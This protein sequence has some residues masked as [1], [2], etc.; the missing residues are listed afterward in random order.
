MQ[1]GIYAI[2]DQAL[3]S[4]QYHRRCCGRS[5]ANCTSGT[6]LEDDRPKGDIRKKD[7]DLIAARSFGF[8]VTLSSCPLPLDESLVSSPVHALDFDIR[9]WI[10]TPAPRRL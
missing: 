7:G 2:S 9:G 1:T 3:L 5:C 10:G 6:V 8:R 4:L